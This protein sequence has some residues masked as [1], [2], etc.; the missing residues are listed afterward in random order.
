MLSVM[1]EPK[2]ITN[3]GKTL[4]LR[5]VSRR[6]QLGISA[7]D[8]ARAAGLGKNGRS[9]ISRLEDGYYDDPGYSRLKA[10]ATALGVSADWLINGDGGAESEAILTPEA[11]FSRWLNTDDKVLIAALVDIATGLKEARERGDNLNEDAS[12]QELQAAKQRNTGL[13]QAVSTAYNKLMKQIVEEMTGETVKATRR[14][15]RLND[16]LGGWVTLS[17]DNKRLLYALYKKLLDTSS[18]SFYLCCVQ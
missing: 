2:Q 5:I 9:Y 15:H 10:I 13:L 16:L 1:D 3:K 6:E 12:F 11:F 4:G 17:D 8:L 18:L 14:D 7:A